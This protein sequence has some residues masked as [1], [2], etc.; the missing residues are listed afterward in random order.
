MDVL[1]RFLNYIAIE[2]TSDEA[3]ESCPSSSGQL[4]LA[5]VLTKE[6]LALGLSD[7]HTDENGYVM[8]TLPSN[9]DYD[10]PTV[11]FIAH[12]DTAPDLTTKNIAPRVLENYDG[13]PIVLNETYNIILSPDDFPDLKDY[14]GQDL[15]VTDGSTLLGADDKAGVA[16]IM[17][18]VATLVHN[19]K[20]PHGKIRIGFTPD[21][22]IGRGAD[23]FDVTKFG[24]TYAYTM[25]GGPIGELEYES[26]NANNAKVH[27]QG[28]NVHPG[29]AKDRM[30]NALEIIQEFN[31]LLPKHEKPEYTSGYEGF[32]HLTQLNGTVEKASCSFI[33]RDHDRKKFEYKKELFASAADFLNKKYGENT[34][35]V[36]L[37]D[38]YYNMGE[39]IDPVY[40][41]VEIAKQAMLEEGIEP[42]IVPIR[43]GTDGSRL[44]YMGLPCPNIFA[45][46]HNFHGKHEFVPVQSMEKAVKVILNIVNRYTTFNSK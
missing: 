26:F 30:I 17:S 15:V 8:A 23:H 18:A 36:E 45:G 43:G 20:L 29:Y 34:V 42:H 5:N 14:V 22:E 39:K 3:S 7:A 21:E 10:V 41:I 28:R 2:T 4:E 32:F 46:G 44:S 40:E 12:M 31:A 33:I 27:V 19:P 35:S 11:G 6:L 13:L 25:D 9:L 1:Q 24:A 38:M 37:K 16:E